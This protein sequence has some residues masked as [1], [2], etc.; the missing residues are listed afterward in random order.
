V[1]R[2]V[3]LAMLR[4]HLGVGT[5][6]ALRRVAPVAALGMALFYLLRP[7][8][9]LLLVSEIDNS[10]GLLLG[11]VFFMIL[12]VFASLAVPRV[13][14]GLR[15]WIRHLPVSSRTIRITAQA[16]VL[17][18]LTP[19][20][21]AIGLL[22]L[23]TAQGRPFSFAVF[24]PGLP[25]MGWAAAQISQRIKRAWLVRPLALAAGIAAASDR[26]PVLASAVL[27]LLT[28]EMLSGPLSGRRKP[29][30]RSAHGKN[31][32]LPW[33]ILW[34]ALRLRLIL[35]YLA[36]LP[37]F[38]LTYAYLSN[39]I[40]TPLQRQRALLF[41][42]VTAVVVFA[43][44]IAHTAAL[45]RPAWPWGRGLPQTS[46]SRVLWDAGFLGL[47]ALPLLFPLLGLDGGAFL[48]LMPSLPVL[49]VYAAAVIRRAPETRMPGWGPIL[50]NGLI[51][52]MLVAVLPL[53]SF[54]FLASLPLLM[55]YGT[56]KER[57]RKVSR[58]L[59]FHHLAAG[60]PHSWSV[61]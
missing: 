23:F 1:K 51:C 22:Y 47:H 38:L 19:V 36:S 18:S 48:V 31:R 49:C 52:G 28:G 24:L 4:F 25:L 58:W 32:V 2:N 15:G 45:R 53:S 11:A 26:G 16:G 61:E 44:V 10:G 59:E 27:L 9:F 46:M 17:M 6:L 33:L 56:V 30:P 54:V 13:F 7:D 5:R 37:P 42:T 34:R 40:V 8:F 29:L 12:W 20:L 60:D 14:L 57:E 21:V 35:G 50:L 39:N 55:R 43:S 41:G 3:G